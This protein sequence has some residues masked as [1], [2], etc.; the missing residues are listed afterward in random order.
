MTKPSK[1][2]VPR[3]RLMC[4]GDPHDDFRFVIHSV[5]RHAPEAIILL[6]DLQAQRPLQ[7][8]LAPIL[9]LTEV[10]F[11]HGNHDT[12]SEADFDNLFK[13]ELAHRNVHGRVVE[14]AGVRVA[15]LGGV[16]R[17]S[18]WAPPLAPAFNSVAERLKCIRPSERWR[19][20]IPL[21][22]RSSIW[23]DEYARLSRQ[24][25]DVLVT[26]EALGGHP[27]GWTALDELASSMGVRMVAHGHL[28]EQIDYHAEGRLPKDCGYVAFGV[29]PDFF[30]TW[31]RT[32]SPFERGFA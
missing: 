18:I 9:A 11:V 27:H 6:G 16:F 31:P 23:P 30:L 12:D 17:E 26:H 21:R 15:G 7:I 1:N 24:R 32:A 28:H 13:S 2:S 5:L 22:H 8:E 3:P 4:F 20:G 19:G 29:G 10:W 14:I 25:A